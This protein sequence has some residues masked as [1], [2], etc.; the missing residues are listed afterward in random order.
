MMRRPPRST[1]IPHATLFRSQAGRLA[2]LAED[3]QR[4]GAQALERERRGARLERA[5]A[6]HRRAALPDR[7]R[8]VERLGP[9]LDRA[10]AGDRKST[11]LNSSH[12]N[13]LYAAL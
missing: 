11:R 10:R 8:D 6:Q 4:L 13:I 3:L 12:T 2:R 7:A 1:L 5:A 9:R